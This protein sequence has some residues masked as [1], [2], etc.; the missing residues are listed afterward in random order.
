M[1]RRYPFNS[2][3][4][5]LLLLV[6]ICSSRVHATEVTGELKKWHRI[7]LTIEGPEISETDEYNPFLNY[8]MEVVFENGANKYTVP[9]FYAGD[10]KTA[11]TSASSGNKW[12]VHFIPDKEGTW[13]YTVYFSK[14]KSIRVWQFQYWSHR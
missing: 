7:S 6:V 8:R 12:R 4:I 13:K 14:G 3:V 5:F 11:E 2:T 10:G 9:G 1:L